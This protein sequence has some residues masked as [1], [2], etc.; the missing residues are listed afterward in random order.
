MLP[1]C[2]TGFTG[3]TG[4]PNSR[5]GGG[6][7]CV[8][9]SAMNSHRTLA[10]LPLVYEIGQRRSAFDFEPDFYGQLGRWL[11]GYVEASGLSAPDQVWTYGAW[12]NG[13]GT[14]DSW[15]NAGR[16]FDLARLRLRG[17]GFV[18]CRYDL[19]RSETGSRLERSQRRYWALA[20][21]LHL[22]FAYVLTYLYNA[23]HHNHI[24]VD[25]SRSGAGQSSLSTRSPAQLQA[26]QGILTH[27]WNE[28][29]E[30]TGR[31]DSAT[32]QATRRVLE[33]VGQG[34][35][36]DDGVQS[37]RAFLAAS[38]PRGGD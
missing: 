2:S 33:R 23:R 18:S 31:W 26:V 30:I 27:L 1:G 3:S 8:P 14:C 13:G 21:S 7:V 36:L 29:V 19:W 17:G 6:A 38:V 34:G 37:W 16:A 4:E 15:H 12:T 35:D 32:Q 10:R 11:T 24:H 20:A 5:T 9:R 25:N 22:D 28:P